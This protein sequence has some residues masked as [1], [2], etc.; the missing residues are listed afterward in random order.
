M[1]ISKNIVPSLY[2]IAAILFFLSAIISK[3]NIYI[4]IGYTFL[5]IGFLF[6]IKKKPSSKNKNKRI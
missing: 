1:K 4:T 5:C 2:F 3:N 6:T